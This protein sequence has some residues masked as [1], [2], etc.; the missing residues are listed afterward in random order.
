MASAKFSIRPVY[1]QQSMALKTHTSGPDAKNYGTT[2]ERY[3]Q[4]KKYFLREIFYRFLKGNEFNFKGE[5][6]YNDYNL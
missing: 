6:L 1:L 3:M 4:F 5:C 2:L